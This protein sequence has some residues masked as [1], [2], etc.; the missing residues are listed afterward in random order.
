MRQRVDAAEPQ[1]Q[2]LPERR[3]GE[4]QRGVTGARNEPGEAVLARHL[5]SRAAERPIFLLGL[6]IY[7]NAVY[8]QYVNTVRDILVNLFSNAIWAWG[9]LLFTSLL[10][11]LKNLCRVD[12]MYLIK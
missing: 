12:K 7:S 11:F 4:L 5:P 6:I 2:E 10:A 8:L 1:T 3:P 9:V